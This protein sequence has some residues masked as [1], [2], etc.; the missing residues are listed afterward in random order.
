M[1]TWIEITSTMLHSNCGD[2]FGHTLAEALDNTDYWQ[3]S[4]NH[5]HWFIID[6]GESKDIYKVA[7]YSN[8]GNDPTDVDIYISD[9]PASFTNKIIDN[10]TDWQD[11]TSYV[12][13]ITD[14]GQLETGRY[15]KI[16]ILSTEQGPNFIIWGDDPMLGTILK[17]YTGS[18]TT[19]TTPTSITLAGSNTQNVDTSI[20][21]LDADHFKNVETSINLSG[22]NTL[23]VTS[24]I[25]IGY[26]SVT[27]DVTSSIH[28]YDTPLYEH[29][30]SENDFIIGTNFDGQIK[31]ARLYDECLDSG[32]VKRNSQGNINYNDLVAWWDMTEGTGTTLY[33]KK[34]SSA[35]TGTITGAVWSWSTDQLNVSSWSITRN[36]GNSFDS[37]TFNISPVYLD[38]KTG[39]E[40]QLYNSTTSTTIWSGFIQHRGRIGS[41]GLV[42]IEAQGLGS[43]IS[44]KK[45]TLDLTSKSPEYI[46][47]QALSQ[48]ADTKGRTYTLS[49][50]IAS[51]IVIA[52]YS[53]DDT[54]GRIVG[55]MIDR[56]GYTLRWTPDYTVYFEPAGNSSSGSSINSS[57]IGTI[58]EE[59]IQDN[60]ESLV[61]RVNVDGE[62][63]VDSE[64]ENYSGDYTD[65]ASVAMYG[66]HYLHVKVDYLSSDEEAGD[67]AEMLI[68]VDPS[69]GGSVTL[70]FS[71][72]TWAD[73]CNKTIT[74]VDELRQINGTYTVYSQTINS[75]GTTRLTVGKDPET[76]WI[77]RARERNAIG[78]ERARLIGSTSTG[79]GG[80][81]GNTGLSKGGG[82]SST[83]LGM[84]GG[85]GS[86]G[87]GGTGSTATGGGGH[88]HAMYPAGSV[89]YHTQTLGLNNHQGNDWI[90]SS[91]QLGTGESH[92]H[93]VNFTW[94]FSHNT[95]YTN[96][97]SQTYAEHNATWWVTTT[98]IDHPHG[99]G[100]ITPNPSSHGHTDD[101]YVSPTN[102]GHTDD[103]YVN[104][105]SHDHPIT[106][107]DVTVTDLTKTDR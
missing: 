62:G 20:C 93:N 46:L 25:S 100:S 23:E 51:G 83:G 35:L 94:N 7:S 1:G 19:Q 15:L 44:Y 74:I 53:I 24:S 82:V 79:V 56:T 73:V 21:I 59:W 76:R 40:I 58:F 52:N 29:C 6:L 27:L 49:T 101:I 81:S 65:N 99:V 103:I 42:T 75:D 43:D 31:Y 97:N 45:V 38:Y 104:P 102:H 34:D 95:G 71:H 28:L 66:E 77:D 84:G 55:E 16:E 98:N 17:I 41:D 9:N 85:V 12:E 48:V 10:I 64:W 67:L 8:T 105:A 30:G 32:Q 91:G 63:Y 2:S 89:H 14:S 3:H 70:P 78:A 61:N 22:T 54:F 11:T 50:P 33:N 4:Y 13:H 88:V 72:L 69:P 5:T 36:R 96:Y 107:D 68:R 47:T 90:S 87:L 86:T 80:S 18:S 92:Y 106:V 37:A 60:P 26:G 39:D 57:S